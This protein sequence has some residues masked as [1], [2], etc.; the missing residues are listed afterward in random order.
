MKKFE[1]KKIHN[2]AEEPALSSAVLNALGE[3]GWELCGI[4]CSGQSGRDWNFFFKRE[5]EATRR[6]F[7]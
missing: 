5:I 4:G 2:P 1:Y 3:D 6:N 7:E